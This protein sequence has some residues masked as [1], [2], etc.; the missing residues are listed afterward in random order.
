M[1]GFMVRKLACGGRSFGRAARQPARMILAGCGGLVLSMA[2]AHAAE[3]DDAW[4][5]AI[6]FKQGTI[7]ALA[8]DPSTQTV[9]S[10]TVE[11]AATIAESDPADTPPQADANA[12]LLSIV[13]E[14]H[15]MI[16]VPY[17]WGGNDPAKGIDCSGFVRYVFQKTTGLLL[18]RQSAQISKKGSAVAESDLS[19]G[20]LVFF[21]TPRGRATHVGIYLGSNQFIHAPRTGAFVRVESL[22]SSYWSSRYFG[23]RRI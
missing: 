6:I 17:R 7:D 22:N 13:E 21:N 20:D 16:G 19:P 11:V 10:G 23:A 3:R 4:P 9:A 15:T 18:P 1:N 14:A 8:A 2:T 12:G 5:S